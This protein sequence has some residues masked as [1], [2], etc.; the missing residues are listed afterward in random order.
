M[1]ERHWSNN[2]QHLFINWEAK[3]IQHSI[4][5]KACKHFANVQSDTGMSEKYVETRNH[6]MQIRPDE[7]NWT[8]FP[9]PTRK[10]KKNIFWC[11]RSTLTKFSTFPIKTLQ[12]CK[13]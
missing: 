4:F 9:I 12:Y 2:Y 3:E 1:R 13:I 11:L 6:A 8:L 5:I 10:T 7:V